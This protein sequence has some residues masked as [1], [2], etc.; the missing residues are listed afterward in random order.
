MVELEIR[1]I[2]GSELSKWDKFVEE[3]KQGTLFSTTLW[4][5]V[6]N[7]YP[8]GKSK[9]L[10]IFRENEIISGILLY[11]RSKLFLNIMAYPP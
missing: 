3:S 1:E 6:L 9:I 11:E 2:E 4:M 7:R 10:G 8:D 5:E